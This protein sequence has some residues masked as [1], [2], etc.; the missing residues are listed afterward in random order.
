MTAPDSPDEI[1]RAV[2]QAMLGH[3]PFDGWSRAAFDMAVADAGVDAVLARDAFPNGPADVLADAAAAGD[4]ALLARM[5][6]PDPDE[7][8]ADRLTRAMALRLD[9][10]AG[11]ED[12]VRR[13]L[14]FLA[15]PGNAPL[16]MRL[17]MRTVDA[18]RTAAGDSATG[19]RGMARR[20]ALASVYSAAMLVWLE[21]GSE[22]REVTRD[23]LARRLRPLTAAGGVLE[24]GLA[25]AATLPR[26]MRAAAPGALPGPAVLDREDGAAEP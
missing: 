5:S 21:D 3:V 20:N 19:L 12:A 2:R 22:A 26:R 6:A 1:R 9:Y 14:T 7:D 16:G 8:A 23:F 15:T 18:V 24:Q 4:A 17:M 25:G 10:N 11:R 13:G